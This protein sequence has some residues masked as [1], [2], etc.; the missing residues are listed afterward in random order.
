MISTRA[1]VQS[2][3]HIFSKC[4]RSPLTPQIDGLAISGNAPK[5]FLRTTKTGLPWVAI[6]LGCLFSLLSYMSVSGGAG[7]VFGWFANMTSVAG[8]ITW[9]GISVTYI[10]FYAGLKAQGIDRTK[11]PFKSVLQPYAAWYAASMILI[12]CIVRLC[13]LPNGQVLNPFSSDQWLGS[14]PTWPLGCGCLCHQLHSSRAFPYI[15]HWRKN[16][17]QTRARQS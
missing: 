17:L 4:I 13:P 11:L 12:I 15:V 8:L 14:I 7:R 6:S 2:V 10:R 9:F 5:I 1:L 3:R 16:L